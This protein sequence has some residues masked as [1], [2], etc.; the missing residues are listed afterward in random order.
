MMC[1]LTTYLDQQ[2]RDRSSNHGQPELTAALNLLVHNDA[3]LGFSLS[4]HKLF[5]ERAASCFELLLEAGANPNELSY[6]YP[7]DYTI[8][9]VFLGVL[10]LWSPYRTNQGVVKMPEADAGQVERILNAF[11]RSGASLAVNFR[12]GVSFVHAPLTPREAI[13][14]IAENEQRRTPRDHAFEDSIDW[15]VVL[16]DTRMIH[17]VPVTS[18]S[19]ENTAISDFSSSK[20]L[21]ASKRQG[22]LIF[23]KRFLPT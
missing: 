3:F 16:M 1:S 17:T 10:L 2:L 11:I 12:F 7:M 6:S 14:Q 4:E 23:L 15:A 21:K 19:N 5:S 9:T 18:T 20:T 8:W 22:I 13:C